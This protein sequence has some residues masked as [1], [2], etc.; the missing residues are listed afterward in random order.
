MAPDEIEAA[1]QAGK[2]ALVNNGPQ[3]VLR[4]L[5]NQWRPRVT[6]T[7]DAGDPLDHAYLHARRAHRQPSGQNVSVKLRWGGNEIESLTLT[8]GVSPGSD[9]F[10]IIV[11]ACDGALLRQWAKTRLSADHWST[12]TD[13][14][15]LAS[16]G[17]DNA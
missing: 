3:W 10:E 7:L 2:V 1:V 17:S 5:D 8:G 14:A 12:V 16:A 4:W 15:E 9:R 11:R 13:F 6:A